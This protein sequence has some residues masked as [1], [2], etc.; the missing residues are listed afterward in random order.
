MKGYGL[1]LILFL[2]LAPAAAFS[3]TEEIFRDLTVVGGEVFTYRCD[4]GKIIA[5]YYRL[6]DG[7]LPFVRLL[8]P[9]GREYTLPQILSASGARYTDEAELVW[10]IKGEEAF[11]EV[12]DDDGQW[13]TLYESCRLEP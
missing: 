12:R 8:F 5:R 3:N 6:S 9:D 1:F 13:V 11:V 10:W 4:D 2:I 7:S